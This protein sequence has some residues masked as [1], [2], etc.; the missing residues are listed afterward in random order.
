MYEKVDPNVG[1]KKGDSMVQVCTCFF[2]HVSESWKY[3]VTKSS[4]PTIFT[5]TNI[6]R[7]IILIKKQLN[8][9]ITTNRGC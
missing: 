1:N 4:H 8:E 2:A 9:E 5:L 7:D 3:N 6:G